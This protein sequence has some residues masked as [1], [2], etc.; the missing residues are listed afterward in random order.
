MFGDRIKKANPELIVSQLSENVLIMAD[1]R[2]LWRVFDDIFSNVCKYAQEFTRVYLSLEKVGA[3]AV[4]TFKNTSRMTL[5][6]SV[7]ELV[8]RFVRGNKSRS[9]EG[10]GLGLSIARSL[11]Q[12]QN[13]DLMVSIDGDLFKVTVK[14]PVME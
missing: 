13:G 9:T 4:I 2:R 6:I 14:F 11:T 10:N 1:G 3:E 5:N 12:L 7:E 8:E